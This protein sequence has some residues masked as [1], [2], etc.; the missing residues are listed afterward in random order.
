M[1]R[2]NNHK[3]YW[4]HLPMHT[5]PGTEGQI[6]VARYL[7]SRIGQHRRKPNSK[8]PPDFLITVLYQGTAEECF[9]LERR[10][11]PSANIG[12]N[13]I[14]GGFANGT[15]RDSI[16]PW[17][18]TKEN[19]LVMS[20]KAK[21][22]ANTPEGRAGLSKAARILNGRAWIGRQH[23]EASKEAIGTKARQRANT[24]EGRELMRQAA[25]CIVPRERRCSSPF[26]SPS[27]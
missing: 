13:C 21:A 10:L 12:W 2:P 26:W 6:G 11:R 27:Y 9:A 1:N 25:L 20:A 23:K 14:P 18:H 3:V 16:A 17:I 5:D 24:P 7:Q 19:K 15:G 22:R 4:L 8:V